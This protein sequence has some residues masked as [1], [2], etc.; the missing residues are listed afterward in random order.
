M[1]LPQLRLCRL[2]R[3]GQAQRLVQ[4]SQHESKRTISARHGGVNWKID[5]LARNQT[6][7]RPGKSGAGNFNRR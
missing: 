6:V 4:P 2:G 7:A 3:A 5:K 1:V